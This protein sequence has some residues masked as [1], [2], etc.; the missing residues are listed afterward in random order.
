MNIII[1]PMLLPTG[2]TTGTDTKRLNT[3][4]DGEEKFVDVTMMIKELTAGYVRRNMHAEL[5]DIGTR[6]ATRFR[7]EAS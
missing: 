5:A 3:T 7:Q 2:W 4:T 6:P 1:N